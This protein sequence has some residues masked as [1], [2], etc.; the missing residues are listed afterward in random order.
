MSTEDSNT[1]KLKRNPLIDIDE[2]IFIK[3]FH[4]YSFFK[5]IGL[6]SAL[7][8]SIVIL[9]FS[10]FSLYNDII[11]TDNYNYAIIDLIVIVLVCM[12]VVFYI[13]DEFKSRIVT[14]ILI[15]SA[16]Q[17]GIYKRMH[18]LIENIAKA[19]IDTNLLLEK[20][21]KIDLK[22]QNLS[23][24]SYEK[25]IN[26][27]NIM[28]E[29]IALGTS[30]KFTVK[31]IFFITLTMAVFMLLVNFNIGWVTQYAVLSIFFIW[32]CFITNEYKLWNEKNAWSFVFLPVLLV[33]VIVM[34]LNKTL[35]YN[36]LIAT[37]YF[38]VGSYTIVYYLWANYISTGGLPFITIKKQNQ[39]QD[40]FSMQKN[41]FFTDLL[42]S[43]AS[44][45]EQKINKEKKK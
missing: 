18:P 7:I 33:P 34:V 11:L 35:N 37:L 6:M 24:E 21:E 38:F 29:P 1:L 19:H 32:W 23:K 2:D 25:E 4:Q 3:P 20:V 13:I 44:R 31:S 22:I 10:I 9:I 40:F 16:F 41:G 15:D 30:I 8:I 28:Q 36:L 17:E 26:T 39:T 43:V 5:K 45:L 42:R 27:D 14:D 12:F